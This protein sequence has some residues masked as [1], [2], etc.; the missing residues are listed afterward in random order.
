MLFSSA[1]M[2]LLYGLSAVAG[3]AATLYFNIQ[4]MTENNGFSVAT[5]ISDNYVN[6]ASASISNDLLVVVAVFFIWS[7]VE[8]RRLSMRFWWCYPV[9]TFT[10]A[11]AFALPLFLL[12]RERRLAALTGVA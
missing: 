1:K 11:I 8:A 3:V 6:A 5:F 10:V 4:F 9:L 2:Q 12:F 7:F